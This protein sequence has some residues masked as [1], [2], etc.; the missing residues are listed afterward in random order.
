M[1][2]A[3]NLAC[4]AVL[5]YPPLGRHM[6]GI[7]HRDLKSPNLL[8]EAT[9]RVKVAGGLLFSCATAML[10]GMQNTNLSCCFRVCLVS[11]LMED[12]RNG[13][14]WH[15]GEHGVPSPR[16]PDLPFW[17]FIQTSTCPSCWAPAA[18]PART[19]PSAAAAAGL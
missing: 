15:D 3:V 18:L 19:P 14:A 11:G 10:L 9:W 6:R 16:G 1:C 13:H 4:C 7:V 5:C 17:F 2:R 8:V 12:G